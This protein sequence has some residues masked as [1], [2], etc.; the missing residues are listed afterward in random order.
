MPQSKRQT[1]SARLWVT[2]GLSLALSLF[3]QAAAPQ[4][5]ESQAAVTTFSDEDR[6]WGVAPTTTPRTRNYHAPT[7]RTIPGAKVIR[8]LELKSLMETDKAA[9]VIDV[10]D[11][12]DTQTIAGAYWLPGAGDGNFHG[13]EKA[14]FSSTLD[15]LTNGNKKA[16]V[17]FLCRSSECWNSYN[18]ALYALEFGYGNVYWYRGGRDAW[19]GA[20]LERR[21][22]QR[23]P[24]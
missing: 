3:S 6:D 14:R 18:A 10:L 21:E 4:T 20:N 7:P 12:K 2:I 24:W 8:T 23:M 19:K 11:S 1:F 13:A 22:A 16:P 15:R 9:V 17:I 5:G